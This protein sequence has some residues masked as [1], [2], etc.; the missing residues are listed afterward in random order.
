M[1]YLTFNDLY[2]G[3]YQS[4]VIDVITF[5]E[6]KNNLSIQLIAFVPKVFLE[7]QKEKIQ[8]KFN[9]P[10]ANVRELDGSYELHLFAPGFEKND[11]KIGLTEDVLSISV[12]KKEQTNENWKRQEYTPSGFVRQFELND[13]MQQQLG[14]H[15][16]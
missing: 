12:E 10:P 14:Y 4:Q 3:I 11:F 5:L 16:F 6:K 9:T 1:V 2:T 7:E 13:K 15:L 8:A